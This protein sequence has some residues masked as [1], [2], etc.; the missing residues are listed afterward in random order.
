MDAPG[1]TEVQMMV[2]APMLAELV[3]VTR[4]GGKRAVV[5]GIAARE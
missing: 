2:G 1:C 4:A 5:W 3:W